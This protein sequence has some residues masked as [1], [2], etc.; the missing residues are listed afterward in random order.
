MGAIK[1]LNAPSVLGR[2]K[3]LMS[4]HPRMNTD[5]AHTVEEFRRLCSCGM[6]SH[7]DSIPLSFS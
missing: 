1:I 3:Y 5:A 6:I 4:W 7:L 2:F